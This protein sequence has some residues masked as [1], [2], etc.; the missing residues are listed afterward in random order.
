MQRCAVHAAV[1]IKAH[2]SRHWRDGLGADHHR[3]M[4][5][6]M[7]DESI[8]REQTGRQT[9]P[10]RMA[11]SAAVI[12]YHFSPVERFL[13]PSGPTG[14]A[15]VQLPVEGLLPHPAVSWELER[16]VSCVWLTSDPEPV[17]DDP[18]SNFLPITVLAV[19]MIPIDLCPRSGPCR[20]Y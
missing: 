16:R 7:A 3:G 1:A 10:S 13:V 11:G 8:H 2:R 14:E 20:P 15:K 12:L 19:P 9:G 6:T 17:I 18:Q 4:G 5:S